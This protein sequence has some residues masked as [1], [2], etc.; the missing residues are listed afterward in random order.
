MYE[1]YFYKDFLF[2]F[3][4]S[5]L[6]RNSMQVR[7]EINSLLLYKTGRINHLI[8]PHIYRND[9]DFE[10]RCAVVG[11]TSNEDL[12]EKIFLSCITLLTNS[13]SYIKILSPFIIGI[14]RI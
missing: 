3:F 14:H 1:K 9:A 7:S 13:M 6:S 4:S 12:F 5:S 8:K 10:M 2:R 11:I